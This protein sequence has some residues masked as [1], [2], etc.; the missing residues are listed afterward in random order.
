MKILAISGSPR[1]RDRSSTLK[2]VKTTAENT[3]LEFELVSLAGKKIQG[4]I[5]C[6]GCADDNV[7]KLKDDFTPLREKIIS[8]DAYILGGCNFFSTLN[9]TMHCFLERWYQFRHREQSFLWGK[10]AVIVSVGGSQTRPV[11]K[12]IEKFCLYNL[13]KVVD[14][15]DGFGANGCYYCGYGET[16]KEGAVVAKYGDGFKITEENIPHVSKDR[17]CIQKACQAGRRL[18]KILTDGHDREKATQEARQAM[19]AHRLKQN[20]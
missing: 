12:V 4:C 2:L 9:G 10:P 14:R 1:I 18:G 6:M 17:A 11:T 5:G 8:A 19:A 3:G 15:V 7:C 13:I 20:E 16:C